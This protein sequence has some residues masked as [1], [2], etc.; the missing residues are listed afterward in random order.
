MSKLC[1]RSLAGNSFPAKSCFWGMNEKSF[2]RGHFLLAF[3]HICNSKLNYHEFS[4]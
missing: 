1:L 3:I 2:L 4:C